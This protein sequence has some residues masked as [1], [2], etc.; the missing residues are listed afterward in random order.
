MYYS[1]KWQHKL[2]QVLWSSSD[3][4]CRANETFIQ[5][6][7]LRTI[8]KCHASSVLFRSMIIGSFSSQSNRPNVP[9]DLRW[10]LIA[11]AR[12]YKKMACFN[13]PREI[14]S[15]T[16]IP[17][18]IRMLLPKEIRRGLCNVNNTRNFGSKKTNVK[19]R[20]CG[21]P[22]CN[23]PYLRCTSCWLEWHSTPDLFQSVNYLPQ[24]R[25]SWIGE[26]LMVPIVLPY[27]VYLIGNGLR[28]EVFCTKCVQ[29][30]LCL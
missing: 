20:T 7:Y 8:T 24:P 16:H 18:H 19:C 30:L 1:L 6:F 4:V 15:R 17:N 28:I 26:V 13:V 10:D 27:F 3:H 14:L 21:V 11:E 22:L 23:E 9:D 29:H 25:R 2:Q 5:S 12:R